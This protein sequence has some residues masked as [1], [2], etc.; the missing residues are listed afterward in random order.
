[1][2]IAARA[3]VMPKD[4]TVMLGLNPTY[5]ASHATHATAPTRAHHIIHR[6]CILQR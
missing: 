1:M 4:A 5:Y 2:A 6:I 3:H